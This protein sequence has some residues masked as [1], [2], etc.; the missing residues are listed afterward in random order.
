MEVNTISKTML[1]TTIRISCAMP[2]GGVGSG[3][4][5]VLDIGVGDGYF[6][7]VLVTNKHVVQGASQVVVHV[8]ARKGSGPDLGKR[9]DI[10]VNPANAPFVGHPDPSVDITAAPLLP[11]LGEH[12][13]DVFYK[14]LSMSDLP[15]EEQASRFDALEEVTFVGYPNG[16]SDPSN[17]TPIIRRGITA[18][19]LTLSFGHRPVFLVDGSV[20]GGSSGS[21]VFLYNSGSYTDGQGGIIV[22]NRCLLVGIMAET[23]VRD[24]YLPLTVNSLPHTRVAQEMNLGIAFEW[25]AIAQTVDVLR[26]RWNIHPQKADAVPE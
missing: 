17:H 8:I 5:F 2:G 11:I 24:N 18:T 19:P 4:G 22:G 15:T 25:K 16:W 1:F 23:M 9:L 13:G 20:F 26:A 21:P 3:T 14:S 10:G 12:A 6:V 7:P